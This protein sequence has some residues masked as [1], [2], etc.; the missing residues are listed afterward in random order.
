MDHAKVELILLFTLAIFL[1]YTPTYMH[2]TPF[3]PYFLVPPYPYKAVA[4]IFSSVSEEFSDSE[5]KFVTVDTDVHEETVDRYN[6]QGLPLFAI[7]QRGDV[8]ATHSGAL[9]KVKMLDFVSK[10]LS[11]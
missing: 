11:K 1:R 7:F 4:P 3:L 9:P 2:L 8:I 5:L 6:I 10:S